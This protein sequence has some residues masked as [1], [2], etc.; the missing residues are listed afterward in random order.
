MKY[1]PR[2][3]IGLLRTPLGRQ[4]IAAGF[5]YRAW[6]AYAA[7]ARV[8]RARLPATT[9]VVAVVG[10]FGKTT[11]SRAV[12]AALGLD[13]AAH[14]SANCWEHVARR[15]LAVRRDDANAVIEVGIAK[16]GEM[17]QYA[18]VVRPD[19][20]VVTSIGSE[21]RR[22]LRTPEGTR[23]EKAHMVRALA[24]DGLAVLNG[25]DPN[26]AWM[27]GETRAR[28]V[29]FGLDPSNDVV[30]SDLRLDWPHG[31]EL[32][33][34]ARGASA[35]VRAPLFGEKMAYPLLAAAAVGLEAGR[36]LDDVAHHLAH[37]TPAPGRLQPFALPDDVWVL[38]DEHKSGYETFHAALDAFAAIE[39]RRRIAV[40]GDIGEP[41]RPQ[42][43]AYRALGARLGGIAA[44]IVVVG[45]MHRRIVGGARDAGMPGEHVIDA[46]RAV[47]DAIAL[48][49]GMLRPGDV[50]LLKG[51]DTQHLERIWLA[52]AGRT[53]GCRRVHCDMRGR[54][55]RCPML[56]RGWPDDRRVAL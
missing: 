2:Q 5:R 28:V 8:H 30:G 12:R 52:L 23:D 43:P 31:M 51:R 25:D 24:P 29:T 37:V 15:V 6:P 27:R 33:V 21:H 19:V 42:G 34:A 13:P 50:V 32:T 47:H 1:S 46:G 39:A 35:R 11:T 18:R 56:E 16:P 7:A 41:P 9:R 14:V 10:T 55:D 40:V 45:S 54:C 4:Q 53:V 20:T 3:L 38:R 48:L 26:V 22:S 17:A 49:R 36:T 44:R